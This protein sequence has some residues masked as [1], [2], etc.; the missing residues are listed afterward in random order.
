LTNGT[1]AG[2]R[3][4][5]RTAQ[6]KTVQQN[7]VR[8]V[9]V[10]KKFRLFSAREGMDLPFFFLVMTLLVIG[11][12]MLFSASYASA[13]YTQGDSYFFIKRQLVFAVIGVTAMILLSYFDYHHFHKLA[14]PILLISI[15]FLAIVLVMP[16]TNGVHRWISLGPLGQFQ[17]SEVAKF[18]IILMFAHLISLN[19]SKMDTFRHGILPYLLILLPICLLLVKEPHISAT[20]III[21]LAGI[22]LF[23]GGVKMRWFI[24]AFGAIGAAIVYLVAFSHKLSYTSTR[25]AVWL[26]PFSTESKEIMEK[27]WQTRQSLYAIGSGGL[28]GVGIGQ[29]RQ[30]YLWLPEPENDFVFSVVCEELG[31][32]GALIIIALFVMLVWRGVSISLRAKDKFGM[33]LGVGLVLQVGLQALLNIAVVTNTVPNT[34]ISLPFFSYGGT[35]LVILLSEMGIVLSISRTSSAEKT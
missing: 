10:K 7:S 28:L 25:L 2:R 14:V 13:E 18:A 30:K 26:N 9:R 5:V 11:L 33:L 15:V 6:Q 17:P 35:S 22:M 16:A 12:V 8:P 27:T 3:A 31:F 20:V 1:A 32:I 4:P 21:L 29:S 23:I 24:A 19:F 34:G